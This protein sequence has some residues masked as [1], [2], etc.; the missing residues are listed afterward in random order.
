[1]DG[2]QWLQVNATNLS[3]SC[4]NNVTDP[5]NSGWVF[6]VFGECIVNLRQWFAFWIG[7]S[8]ILFWLVAQVP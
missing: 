6:V 4:P 5:Q 7:L 2:L 3:S 8:S 1:M